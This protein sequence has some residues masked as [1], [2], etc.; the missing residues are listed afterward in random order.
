[1]GNPEASNPKAHRDQQNP[2]ENSSLEISSMEL[3]RNDISVWKSLAQNLRDLFSKDQ[4]PPLVLT[5]KP[6]EV[7]AL[8]HEESLWKTLRGNI[9][10]SFFPDKLPPLEL[11]AQPVPVPDILAVP[12]DTKSSIFSF[13]IHA[14]LIGVILL[15]AYLAG[16]GIKVKPEP[17]QAV[18]L[19]PFMPITTPSLKAMGGGGGGGSHDVVEASKGHLP[20]ID[21]LQITPP[22]VIKVDHPK[23]PVPPTVIMQPIKV[24]DNNLPNLGVQNSPQVKLASNGTGGGAGIGSGTGTGVGVGKGAG[25]GPGSGANYGGGV[26]QIG[27]AVAPPQ[28]VY[29]VEPEFSDE[30]RRAKYQ[31]VVALNVVVNAQGRAVD[32]TVVRHLGMGL[33]QKAIDAVRQYRFRPAIMNGKAVPVYMTIEVDFHLF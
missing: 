6:V 9:K 10:E 30:A 27:G 18:V 29:S 28:L 4:R 20:K 32:I 7:E 14:A 24:P 19:K 13:L 3:L 1:M 25:V 26:Y 11:T 17:E 22:T 33:D 8:L 31:G 15:L 12:R 16:L 23:I 5:S 21:K 2:D